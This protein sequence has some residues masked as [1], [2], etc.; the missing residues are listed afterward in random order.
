MDKFTDIIMLE[1]NNN[2]VLIYV[3]G[4]DN[5]LLELIKMI[6]LIE[7]FPG[8]MFIKIHRSF[9]VNLNHIVS[10]P[11]KYLV[12]MTNEFTVDSDCSITKLF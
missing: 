10:R 3:A 8:S 12:K 5:P 9:Y 4:R 11:S 6:E 7:D 2:Y 1:S